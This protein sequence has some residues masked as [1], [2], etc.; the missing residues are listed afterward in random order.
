MQDRYLFRGRRT[1]GAGLTQKD[2]WP[3]G[4]LLDKGSRYPVYISTPQC[5]VVVDP[6]T[7]GQCTGA[8][9]RKSYRGEQAEDLLIFEGDIVELYPVHVGGGRA[10]SLGKHIVRWSN[11]RAGFW[12]SDIE[13]DNKR[14]SEQRGYLLD[15]YAVEVVGNIHDGGVELS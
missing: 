3:I 2:N 1:S 8:P 5:V 11:W 15:T 6:S 9:A 13:T 7:I 14:Q 12:A 10:K 4:C